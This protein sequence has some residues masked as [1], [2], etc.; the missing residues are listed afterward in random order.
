MTIAGSRIATFG[1]IVTDAIMIA[2]L[3]NQK[4]HWISAATLLPILFVPW[5][6][7]LVLMYPIHPMLNFQKLDADFVDLTEIFD[8]D[9]YGHFATP[10]RVVYAGIGGVPKFLCCDLILIVRYGATDLT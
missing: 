4:A 6:L 2:V 10:L 8:K 1:D 5:A 9:T 3:F 7:M